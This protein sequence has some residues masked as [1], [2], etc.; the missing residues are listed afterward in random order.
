MNPALASYREWRRA[1][2]S[3]SARGCLLILFYQFFSCGGGV[4]LVSGGGMSMQAN[5]YE[6]VLSTRYSP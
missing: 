4:G 1:M 2:Y 5:I 3:E 6:P